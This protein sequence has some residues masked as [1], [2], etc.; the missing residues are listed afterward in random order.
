MCTW[1]ILQ[2]RPYDR[3]RS[4]NKFKKTEIIL[5]IF[6]DHRGMDP[7]IKKRKM[8]FTNMQKLNNAHLN[9]YYVK[10]DIKRE[11][12]S[13]LKMNEHKNIAYQLLWA[14]AKV[15]LRAKFV[16]IHIH[17]YMYIYIKKLGRSQI[18]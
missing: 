4:I 17:I 10:E 6:F 14:V 11:T 9:I 15:V 13:Y 7:E 12:K 18:T 8:R 5:A 1:N 3:K 16:A 2:D